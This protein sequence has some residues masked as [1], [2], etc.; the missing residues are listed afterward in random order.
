MNTIFM[1]VFGLLFLVTGLI[2]IQKVKKL[3]RSMRWLHLFCYGATF[4]LFVCIALDIDV[5]MPTRFFIETVS[6]WVFSMIHPS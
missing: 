4:V 3:K 2:D 1:F 6:P 5:P